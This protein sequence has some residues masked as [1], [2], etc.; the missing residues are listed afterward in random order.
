MSSPARIV[1]AGATG[2]LGVP[3]VRAWADAGADLTILTRRPAA[4]PFAPDHR[5]RAV[6]WTPDGTAGP[7]A[8]ALEGADAVVN[9]AG[10]SLAAH[11]WTPA[12]KARIVD[13]RI[14]ATRSLVNAIGD[15]HVPPRAL[16]SSSGIGYYGP[17]GDE[18]LTEQAAPG[19]DFI[20]QLGAAWEAEAHRAAT[21][22]TRVVFARTSLV[23]AADGGALA[24]MLLPFR[25][26]LG[27]R[28]GSGRQYWAWIHR[29]D[30][31]AMI[32]WAAARDD[33]SGGLNVTS[34]NPV[35]NA[36]FVRALARALHRPAIVPLPAF[37]ARLALGEMADG[38]ILSGQRA[39]PDKALRGGFRFRYE[40]LDDALAAT[41]G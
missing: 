16:V 21:P 40:R 15:A 30:W 18:V 10:E 14:L 28:I 34:P 26:G 36:E 39:V 19:R 31:V 8:A 27:G 29:D 11:R 35:T 3:L 38:L 5:V 12:Q 37:A 32:L 13:S 20:A 41:F 1:L 9:L 6:G 22:R 23:I 25:L 4:S 17:H 33:V 7:W 24:P 2:F